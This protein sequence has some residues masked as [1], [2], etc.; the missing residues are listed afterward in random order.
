MTK[1][2]RNIKELIEKEST[3]LNNLLD[4]EEVKIFKCLT[5]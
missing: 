5:E 4:P 1:E 3:N 2:K